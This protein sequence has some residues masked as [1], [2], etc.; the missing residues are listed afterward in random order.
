MGDSVDTG[1]YFAS[2]LKLGNGMVISLVGR[3]FDSCSATCLRLQLGV[4]GS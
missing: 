4:N 3:E 2:P 1:V